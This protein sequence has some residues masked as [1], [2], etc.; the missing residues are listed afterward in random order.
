MSAVVSERIGRVRRCVF[1]VEIADFTLEGGF[2]FWAVGRPGTGRVWL[3]LGEGCA[4]LG[5]SAVNVL[6]DD[7]PKFVCYSLSI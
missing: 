6:A 2:D 3:A 4:M 7:A 5:M 1:L